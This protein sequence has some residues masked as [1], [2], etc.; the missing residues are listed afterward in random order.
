MGGGRGGDGGGG[1]LLVMLV[2][3]SWD[4]SSTTGDLMTEG[5]DTEPRDKKLKDFYEAIN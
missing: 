3:L 4:G 1:L 5:L 2:V